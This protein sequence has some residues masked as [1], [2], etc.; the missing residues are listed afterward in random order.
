MFASLLVSFGKFWL[1]V[2]ITQG[3]PFQE[4]DTSY[5]VNKITYEILAVFSNSNIF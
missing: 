5:K 3:F 2:S 4:Q 1:R